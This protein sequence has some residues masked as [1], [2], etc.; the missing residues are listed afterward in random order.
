MPEIARNL[1]FVAT[2]WAKGGKAI[3]LSLA[4][5]SSLVAVNPKP[6]SYS[7]H[8]YLHNSSSSSFTNHGKLLGS[9]TS[10]LKWIMIVAFSCPQLWERPD[11]TFIENLHQLTARVCN[12]YPS[13]Q[14]SLNGP[15]TH[16][17]ASTIPFPGSRTRLANLFW[18]RSKG[19]A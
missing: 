8:L 5:L 6:L 19:V 7:Y 11:I 1:P 9:R 18:E 14:F 16:G 17:S 2:E 13:I 12:A 4:W 15:H 3:N 10:K